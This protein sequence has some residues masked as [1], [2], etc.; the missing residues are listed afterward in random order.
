MSGLLLIDKSFSIHFTDIE[1]LSRKNTK[2]L[3]PILLANN[4]VPVLQTYAMGSI[5]GDKVKSSMVSYLHFR[6]LFIEH[7]FY[8]AVGKYLN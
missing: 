7:N 8:L 4:K 5:K 6:T 3:K 1:T 2:W